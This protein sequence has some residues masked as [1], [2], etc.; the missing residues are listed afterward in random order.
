MKKHLA[1]DRLYESHKLVAP[2]KPILCTSK[3]EDFSDHVAPF[4]WFIPIS[5]NPPRVG[6]ALLARPEKQHTLV[7]IERTGEFVINVP[8]DSML[9][10]LVESSYDLRKHKNKFDRSEFKRRESMEVGPPGIEECR[11]HF[12]C[13]VKEIID[14]GDHFFIIGDVLGATYD[15][16][17]FTEE[18]SVKIDNF[19]PVFHVNE[20]KL[21]GYQMHVFLSA[22]CL[23]VVEVNYPK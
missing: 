17:A 18:L 14:V 7:N 20:Y 9:E 2:T 15:T 16:D 10:K 3:N 23:K 6:L 19:R 1:K 11:V 21:H 22:L 13:K 8:D 12:E 4:S 5:C